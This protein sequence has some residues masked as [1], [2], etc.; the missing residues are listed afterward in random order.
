MANKLNCWEFKHCG[1]Q[2]GGAKV[3]ELGVCPA[4][5]AQISNGINHGKNGGRVCWALAGTL[6]GGKVQG[7]FAQKVANCM[8]CP[9][10]AAVKQEEGALFKL[11]A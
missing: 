2:A 11:V 5:T 8:Q 3:T 10:Y 4:T 9:F 6:C 1:R 7:T